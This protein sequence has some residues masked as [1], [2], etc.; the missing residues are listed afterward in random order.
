VGNWLS[1]IGPIRIASGSLKPANARIDAILLNLVFAVLLL[2]VLATTLLPLGAELL[3]QANGWPKALPICLVLSVLECLAVVY[4]YRFF[5]TR[6]G[7]MLQMRERHILKV[8]TT[9]AE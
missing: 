2:L 9:K 8:V 4:L 6:H 5:L 1:I 3:L 7:D